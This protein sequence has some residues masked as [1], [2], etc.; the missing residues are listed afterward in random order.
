MVYQGCIGGVLEV[1]WGCI[2]GVSGVYW[3][4]IRAALGVNMGC[5][6]DVLVGVYEGCIGGAS[7]F[8]WG[9]LSTVALSFNL[10]RYGMGINVN[11][12]DRMRH[13][14]L[15]DGIREDNQVWRRRLNR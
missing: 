13:T 14:P 1:Y 15:D 10:R 4:H 2:R 11:S 3:G 5:I 9:S 6:G 8:I 12:L 7:G